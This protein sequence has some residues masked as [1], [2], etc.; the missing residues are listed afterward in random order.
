VDKVLKAFRKDQRAY[1]TMTVEERISAVSKKLEENWEW[2]ASN[3]KTYNY[4]IHAY[5]PGGDCA[6]RLHDSAA[7]SLWGIGQVCAVALRGSEWMDVSG[8]LL[9]AY[10]DKVEA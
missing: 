2:A 4:W 6:T 3:G 10:K 7:V 1:K 5:M 8:C 9:K